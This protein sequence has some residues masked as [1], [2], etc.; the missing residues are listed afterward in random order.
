MPSGR[1]SAKQA[2]SRPWGN[3][4][5]TM[6]ELAQGRAETMIEDLEVIFPDKRW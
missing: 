3:I 2:A 4:Q 5:D 1:M 6:L